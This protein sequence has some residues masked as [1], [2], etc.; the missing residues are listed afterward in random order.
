M[1]GNGSAAR[2][3]LLGASRGLLRVWGLGDLMPR[4]DNKAA[5]PRK[6]PRPALARKETTSARDARSKRSGLDH[7]N[8]FIFSHLRVKM[9]NVHEENKGNLIF[10]EIK[11]DELQRNDA[12]I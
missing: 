1:A 10:I 11:N 9:K 12:Q 8:P 4:A 6:M 2:R 3:R 7:S 5:S